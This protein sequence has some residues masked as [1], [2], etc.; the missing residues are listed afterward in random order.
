MWG[1]DD[2]RTI[3]RAA[4]RMGYDRLALT[5]TD[6][7]YVLWTFLSACRQ[8]GIQPIVGAELTDPHSKK[9]VVCLVET[10]EG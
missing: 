10:A 6:N 4:A 9:R 1:V 8:E 3:C 2:I 7:L 5:D